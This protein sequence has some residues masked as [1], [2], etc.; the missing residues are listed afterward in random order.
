MSCETARLLKLTTNAVE[1]LRFIVPRKSDAFQDDIFPDTYA[2]V[3]SLKADEWL[4]GESKPPVL[5]SLRPGGTNGGGGA[6]V[7]KK[8]FTPPKSA[9]TLQKEV[10]VRF[11]TFLNAPRLT[12]LFSF[13][14]CLPYESTARRSS[15]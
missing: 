13:A 7:P 11:E 1:P 14:F 5:V 6:G 3:P 15:C 12:V 10:R 9:V 8:A 2:G 4:G